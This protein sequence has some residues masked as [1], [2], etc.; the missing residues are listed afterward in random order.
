MSYGKIKRKNDE[1]IKFI[2]PKIHS[3][4][5]VKDTWYSG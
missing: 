1:F 2:S 3:E 5:S 4:L